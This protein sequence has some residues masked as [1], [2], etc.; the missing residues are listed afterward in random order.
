MLNESMSKHTYGTLNGTTYD[1]HE[2]DSLK[3]EVRLRT[4]N[5]SVMKL[6]SSNEL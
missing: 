3:K 2:T 6:Y 5:A 1:E 4:V